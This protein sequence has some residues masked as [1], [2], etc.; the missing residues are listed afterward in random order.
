MTEAL[1][2]VRFPNED[3]AY[4]TARNDLLQAEIDLRRQIER[5]A[6]LRRELPPGGE[7]PQDYEFD[8]DAGPVKLS[9]LFGDKDTLI[10]YSYMYGP[11]MERPC[12]SCTSILDGLNGQ[13]PHVVQRANLVV[14]AKSPMARIR[15]AATER[16]WTRLKLLSSFN[17]SYHS[18]YR[19][20]TED[21]SQMPAI[22]LFTR[23]DGKIRH[24]W[25]AE[26]LYTPFDPGQDGRHVDLIWPMWNL[27]DMTP[28]GRG[29]HTHP[30]LSYD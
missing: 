20:E 2:Q 25:S 19:S 15:A 6:A 23:R 22:N 7:V 9:A 16:G 18:D 28:E 4:R 8:S 13:A 11:K 21:G 1:H 29:A 26:L 10:V 27:L 24:F 12:P 30:K 5:V 14:V 17:N 3:A